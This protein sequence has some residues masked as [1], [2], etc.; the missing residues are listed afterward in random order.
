MGSAAPVHKVTIV[1]RG[2]IGGYTRTLPEEDRDLW[3]KG[4]FEAM[5]A[6]MMGGQS[7]EELVF[8]DITT[9][10]SNDLQN[11][12]RIARK[13][14]TEYGMSSALGPR[15][16]DT[17]QDT[18]FLGKELA[19]GHDYSDAVAEKI[20]G[21]IEGFL[22]TARAKARGILIEHRERLTLLANK[23]LAEESVEGA[24]LHRLLDDNPV[25]EPVAA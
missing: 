16:F 7:A 2:T 13:M 5:L 4:Q 3:S 22:L 11:A 9:G 1:P 19:Q 6:M 21:E 8:G 12:S 23:L 14:V 17:G 25:V 24:E 10:S 18:I 15:S 20:D